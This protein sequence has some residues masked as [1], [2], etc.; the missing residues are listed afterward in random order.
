MSA[1]VGAMQRHTKDRPCPICGGADRDP[2]G[3]GKRCHGFVS[4]DG[5]YAHCTREEHAGSLTPHAKSN[6]YVHRLNGPCRC[7]TQHGEQVVTESKI[8]ATYN[9]LDEDGALLFQVVRKTGKQFLQRRPDNC[10]GWIWKLE[11]TRRVPY[12]LPDLIAA[13][14]DATIYIAEGE[15]D[16]DTLRSL[17]LVAT[18]N[19]GG[20]GKWHYIA[21]DVRRIVA[22]RHVVVLPDADKPG[23]EHG[24]AIAASLEG[25]ASSVTVVELDGAK[26]VTDWIAS[27]HTAD[28]LTAEIERVS[29]AYEPDVEDQDYG[30]AQDTTAKPANTNEIM[31]STNQADVVDQ[32]EA[33]LAARGG[34]Y[35]RARTLVQVV[36]D[37]SESHGLAYPTG[38]PIIARIGRERLR[39]LC[40]AA[41]TWKR[42]RKS[43][44]ETVIEEIMVPPWVPVTLEQREEWSLPALDGISD[45]PVFRADGTICTTPG[46]DAK[47][48]TIY[49]PGNVKYP[50]IVL[51]PNKLQAAEAYARL[52]E[53]FADFPTVADS[54]RAAVVAFILT[55]IARSAING[56]TPMWVARAPVRG[57]GKGLCVDTAT[58]I[59][60]GRTAPK[61]PPATTEDEFRKAMFAYAME[62]PQ[63]VTL[64]NVEG[65]LGSP[66]LAMVL[67]AGTISDR[68]LGVSE[69][70]TVPVR[71]VM[72]ATGNNLRLRGDNDRR[73]VPIDLDPRCER[74]EDR[75]GWRHPDL[76]AHVRAQRPELV[77]AALTI[78]RAFVVADRPSH[79]KPT[80][81]SF[82]AWDRLVRSA[83]IWASGIDPLGGVQRIRD[84]G[85]EDTEKLG[86]LLVAWQAAFG[87]SARTAAEAVKHAGNEGDLYDAIA[88]YSRSG[89]PEAKALGYTLRK[90]RARIVD[91]LEF[92]REEGRAGTCQWVV[93]A[94]N[95][96]D[97]GHGGDGF[98]TRESGSDPLLEGLR[99]SP[100][101]Q[102][103][104]PNR[105]E[106]LWSAEAMDGA[107]Q[108]AGLHGWEDDE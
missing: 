39:E 16:V 3:K 53:P 57:S 37:V 17:G 6:A 7:G 103:S 61:R 64:D 71:F 10:G 52:L 104:P 4:A 19:P 86:A 51:A 76:L 67:T 14:E 29:Y 32:A 72:S 106:A 66:T 24:K 99:S 11:D 85:D 54:D 38:Q 12:R 95:G 27:G 46:Y 31:V 21:D 55:I 25:V 15:R 2:R 88:A 100:P 79:G 70:R 107:R 43:K 23:R 47:S 108:H 13:P 58:V 98:A 50:A 45:V 68:M 44:T 75:T 22:G 93:S 20:A 35:V 41:A 18:T 80:M 48:R 73:V 69:T 96:G 84:E 97:G 9:Y 91:G 77:A 83:V 59:A 87:G 1:A 89:K 30:E 60:T 28:D 78:L 74:P 92:R 62:S 90:V 5:T 101:S 33:A 40:G 82:E 49:E 34:V 81:G 56:C 94:F 36:R 63:T 26:D 105:T 102:P 42:T 8:E 65:V